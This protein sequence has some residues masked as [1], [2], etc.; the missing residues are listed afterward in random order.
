MDKSTLRIFGRVISHGHSQ[1]PSD[2][3]TEI[4]SNETSTMAV[5]AFPIEQMDYL[6]L[7]SYVQVY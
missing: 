4:C 1:C 7:I 3:A 2:S 5:D 6:F